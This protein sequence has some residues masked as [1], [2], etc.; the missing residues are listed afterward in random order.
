MY[1][2]FGNIYSVQTFLP[3]LLP[4]QVSKLDSEIPLYNVT[5]SHIILKSKQS[6]NLSL[7][8]AMLGCFG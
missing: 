5:D 3:S 4:V 2:N 8:V 1:G 6:E 7:P